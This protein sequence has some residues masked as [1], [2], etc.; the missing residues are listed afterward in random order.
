VSVSL[1]QRSVYAEIDR[2]WV[3][4]RGNGRDSKLTQPSF[5]AYH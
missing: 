2:D 1:L 5:S 3:V 4:P